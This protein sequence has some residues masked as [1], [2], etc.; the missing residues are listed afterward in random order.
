M[1]AMLLTATEVAALVAGRDHVSRPVDNL[2]AT[3]RH[4]V[5]ADLADVFPE[6]RKTVAGP[7]PRAAEM[8]RY[9]ATSVLADDGKLLGV[10]PGEFDFV[11]PFAEGRTYLDRN[12]DGSGNGT[13]RIDVK[14][15]QAMVA[16]DGA[17][18]TIAGVSL[19]NVEGARWR[20]IVAVAG[21]GR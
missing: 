14:P 9:G 3:T 21:E 18:W 1:V 11:C 19:A 4:R 15:G 2:Q 10:K 7:G 13:W 16:E 17:R 12:P 5:V 20:W 8:N 6:A